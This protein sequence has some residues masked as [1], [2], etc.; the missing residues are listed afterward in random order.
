MQQDLFLKQNFNNQTFAQSFAGAKLADIS[1]TDCVLN[2]CDFS[3]ADISAA[4]F[5]DCVFNG[6]NLSNVKM[7]GT[8]LR[9]IKFNECKFMGVDFSRAHSFLLSWIFEGGKAEFCDFK[10]LDLRSCRFKNTSLKDSDFSAANLQN[11]KIT[12]CNLLGAVFANT[13]LRGTDLTGSVNC[14]IDPSKNKM[15]G[16]KISLCEAAGLLS[17][18]G[19]ELE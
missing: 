4:S 9:N 10:R 17:P 14:F 7:A 3:R 15:Q 2:N 1:F 13:D 18:F 6:C 19:V 8:K 5:S 11:T 16:A 12:G